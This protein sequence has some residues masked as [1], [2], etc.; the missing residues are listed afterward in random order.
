VRALQFDGK[1]CVGSK[2][3]LLKIDSF[4]CELWSKSLKGEI[5]V[6]FLDSRTKKKSVVSPGKSLEKPRDFC[7]RAESYYI[8]HSPATKRRPTPATTKCLKNSKL[9]QG[10]RSKYILQCATDYRSDH[11]TVLL[12]RTRFTRF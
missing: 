3:I 6:L 9:I 10:V 12:R 11:K 7:Q 8:I 1:K 5:P 4:F 2:L